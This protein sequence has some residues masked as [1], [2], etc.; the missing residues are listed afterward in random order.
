M[1]EV[2]AATTTEPLLSGL[3]QMVWAAQADVVLTPLYGKISFAS[4]LDPAFDLYILAGGGVA[5]TRR[6]QTGGPDLSKT[7]PAFN[8][9][10]G[11]HFFFNRL[12]GIRVELRDFFYPE[13]DPNNGGIT[14][15][16]Q[17]QA[18]LQLAFGGEG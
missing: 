3:Y 13:P 4:E 2:R 12:I 15:N 14:A 17:V 7:T 5:G 11:F 1:D 16:L 18:G 9:G 8:A 10:F 6:K